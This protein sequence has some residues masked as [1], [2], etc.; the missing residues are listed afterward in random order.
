MERLQKILSTAGITSRRKA[1]V[2]IQEGRVTINGQVVT[3]LGSKADPSR[4]HIK[5]DGKLIKKYPRKT[6]ILLNKPRNVISTVADPQGR[7]KVT[8]L[9]KGS[10]R[11]YPVGRL[12]YDS[13]GIILLTNDGEFSRIVSSAGTQLPKVYHV[14]VRSTP[15]QSALDRLQ[16][17]VRLQDGTGLRARKITPLKIANNSWYEV[18]LTQGKNRQIRQMFEKIGHPVMKLYRKRIGFLSDR[19]LPVGHYR[20]LTPQEVD[21]V[22]SLGKQGPPSR[23]RE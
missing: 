10:E 3:E 13:E 4:D 17:G 14:K 15:D 12:D 19:G 11:I 5:V 23:V 6:Y 16:S 8:D 2:M 21:K 22:L 1:E 7:M 18:T 9:I 20:S